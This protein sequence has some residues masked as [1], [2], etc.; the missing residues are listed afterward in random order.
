MLRGAD[1]HLEVAAVANCLLLASLTFLALAV[2]RRDASWMR[3]LIVGLAAAAALLVLLAY[4]AL[5]LRKGRSP[6]G[7][8][9]F[10]LVYVVATA[11]CAFVTGTVA[12]YENGARCALS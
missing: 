8:E 3:P 9:G 7:A 12:V 4:F 6:H 10:L 1:E 5:V 2:G 11:A